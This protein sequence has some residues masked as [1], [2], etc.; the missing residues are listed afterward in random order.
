[1]KRERRVAL[2][3]PCEKEERRARKRVPK[4]ARLALLCCRCCLWWWLLPDRQTTSTT[5]ERDR[6]RSKCL[7]FCFF[8]TSRRDAGR[9]SGPAA[10][11]GRGGRRGGGGRSGGVGGEESSDP[12]M[13]LLFDGVR[14]LR[15]AARCQLLHEILDGDGLSPLFEQLCGTRSVGARL[16]ARAGWRE[17]NGAGPLQW[18]FISARHP[19][20]TSFALSISLSLRACLL[21]C[22]VV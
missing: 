21:R 12:L 19:H 1:M 15:L 20:S 17:E 7:F 10:R 3:R 4:G 22:C 13:E 9:S 18:F 11:R 6:E 2:R 16:F 8:C 5:T 14:D